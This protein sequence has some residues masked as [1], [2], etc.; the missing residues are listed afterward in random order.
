MTD[1]E[2][3]WLT[4]VKGQHKDEWIVVKMGLSKDEAETKLKH[5]KSASTHEYQCRPMTEQELD[6]WRSP[7]SNNR[8]EK[9]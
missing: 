5:M 6:A 9:K 3:L 7:Q 2:T 4:E 1:T 8:K